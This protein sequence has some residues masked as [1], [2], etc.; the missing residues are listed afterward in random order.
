[1]DNKFKLSLLSAALLVALAGCNTDGDNGVNGLDGAQGPQG[2]AGPQGPAGENGQDG[3]DGENGSNGQSGEL[4]RIA[5]VPLGA[6]VTGI[7]LTEQGDLFFNIQHPSSANVELDHNNLPYNRGTVG[8]LAGVD[9]NALPMDLVDSP[10]PESPKEQETVMA[11]YGQYQILGQNGDTYE[12]K[13]ADG[14]GVVMSL[15]GSTAVVDTDMPDF[16]AFVPNG[17]GKGYLF[18]NWEYIPGGMSRLALAKQADGSWVVEDAMMID[19]SA[20]HGTAANCFGTLTPWGTPLS[21]EE[22]IVDSNVAGTT[23]ADWNMPGNS[24]VARMDTMTG[25]DFPNPYRYGYVIEV[26]DPKGTPTPAKHYAMGRYE[27]ENAVVMPDQR[28]VYLSQDDTGGV[29]FKFVADA[30]G[31]LSSG[32]LYGAKLTQDAGSTEPQTTGFDVEWIALG[33]ANND[34]VEAWIAEFDGIDSSDYVDGQSNYLT[35][36]DVQA[37]ADGAAT[38]PTVAEGGNPVTAG[39]PMDNRVVFLE[40]RQAANLKGATAEFRKLEGIN[41]N[42]KRA[43]EAV[44]GTDLI[45]GEDVTEAYVYFAIADLDNTMID[46]EGDIALSSRVKDCGGV[47]RMPLMAGY[48][49]NRIEPVIMGSTY[50]DSLTGAERCDVSQL[51]QPDNVLVMDDGRILI[52][53]DGFQVNNTLWMYRPVVN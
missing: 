24:D 47:Y 35:L 40:S 43:E 27:H 6:E 7:F 28:T 52:G 37:W 23:E 34:E 30:A 42:A 20:V 15:D 18:T 49:V 26:T 17:D 51:S 45:A 2:E 31:D 4:T 44:D 14:L 3:Q 41:I 32:T 33:S 13:L 21:S 50:R 10:V 12:G 46:G 11:A 38:Y 48:D 25:A 22:W 1:M 16:N 53:E 19:F 5:T 8:V 39:Q 36:A 29:M 9:F